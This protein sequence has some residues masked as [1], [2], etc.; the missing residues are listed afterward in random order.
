MMNPT[1]S[2][3]GMVNY[4]KSNP[5]APNRFQDIWVWNGRPNWDEIFQVRVLSSRQPVTPPPRLLRKIV[6]IVS[7][8]MSGFVSV[9]LLLSAL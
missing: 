5:M 1:I 9:V 6:K 4:M 3:K 7:T 2:S 8:P